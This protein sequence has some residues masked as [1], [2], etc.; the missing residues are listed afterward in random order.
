MRKAKK[1]EQKKTK[2]KVT[3]RKDKENT[4][5]ILFI[6]VQ[7]DYNNILCKEILLLY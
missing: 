5:N 4:K 6:C 1:Y 2:R 7:R 3:K